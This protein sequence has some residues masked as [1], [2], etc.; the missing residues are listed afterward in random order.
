MNK[1]L[2][3]LLEMST[4]VLTKPTSKEN[5]AKMRFVFQVKLD[6]DFKLKYK[7]RLVLCGYSQ[8]YKIDYLTTYSP[9]I[10]KDSLKLCIIFILKHN[11]IMEL[12]DFKSAFI[13]GYNDYKITGQ[14]PRELFPKKRVQRKIRLF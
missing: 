2:D 12:Y 4:F 9:T 13:E 1:E 10:G 3:Q 11:M 6:N 14:L 5:I 8:V 7:A